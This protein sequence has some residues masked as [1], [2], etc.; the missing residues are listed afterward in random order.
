MKGVEATVIVIVILLLVAFL[1]ALFIMYH[2]SS[3]IFKPYVPP[4]QPGMF[5]PLGTIT[6]LT[7]AEIA[8]RKQILSNVPPA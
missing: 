3:G 2:D 6:P 8:Q 1:I 4:L 5:Y 7:A